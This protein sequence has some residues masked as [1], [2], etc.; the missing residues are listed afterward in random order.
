MV[1][2]RRGGRKPMAETED[3]EATFVARPE[4]EM[5]A[6]VRAL[7]WSKTPLGPRDGWSESLKLAVDIVL[8]S[9][10]PM[11]L[12][13][14][15]EF[16]LIYNDSYKPIL[17]DK[18]PWALGKPAS[19]AW[20]EVWPQIE[21]FHRQIIDGKSEAVFAEDTLLRIRRHGG[22]WE[23]ARFTLGYSPT[24]DPA[25]PGG[26]GGIFVSAIETTERVEAERRL[27]EARQALSTSN[28]SLESERAFLRDLFQHAPSFMAVV[29][30]PDHRF[31]MVNDAFTELIGGRETA[32]GTVLEALPELAD[33]AFVAHLDQVFATG[34]AFTGRALS[35]GSLSTDSTSPSG[36]WPR[37]P[38]G[39]STTPSN[40]RC[41]SARGSA[42]DC[43]ATPRICWP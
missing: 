6:L 20:A 24:P 29:R 32:G 21:P 2:T 17:G 10:F 18:H 8:S 41:S 39:G 11:A 22:Q 16:V 27:L 37:T 35:R 7:D 34:E 13:W 36:S 3:G 9:G 1:A 15:P 40:N 19:E 4:P 31:E 42:T 28:K 12:R 43:G 23:D 14:G 25:A 30:G 38:C 5:P 33:Q 26:I